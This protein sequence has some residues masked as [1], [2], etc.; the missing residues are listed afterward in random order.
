MLL[1]ASLFLVQCHAC[2]GRIPLQDNPDDILQEISNGTHFKSNEKENSAFTG[3]DLSMGKTS[4]LP[5]ASIVVPGLGRDVL[6]RRVDTFLHS[7]SR[8]TL[9]PREVVLMFSDIPDELCASQTASAR[10]LLPLSVT[11]I[12]NCSRSK[13]NQADARN[14]G[15]SLAGG[16]L[17]IFSDADDPMHFER[18]ETI[19]RIFQHN[20]NLKVFAHSFTRSRS[21][22]STSLMR[23]IDFAEPLSSHS[24]NHR[25]TSKN[26]SIMW[27]DS[28]QNEAA[29]RNFDCRK[30]CWFVNGMV[31]GA[32]T[33]RRGVMA[34]LPFPCNSVLRRSDG[35][36]FSED[37]LWLRALLKKFR[38]KDEA[39]YV[40]LPLIFYIPNGRRAAVEP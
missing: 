5:T 22:L 20:Q 37:T 21:L 1:L 29:R 8:Q 26:V 9:L 3:R 31:P 12:M 32:S 30:R 6:S 34:S 39:L 2:V 13:L 11:V 40:D 4:L 28:L 7:V 35:G 27:G 25:P 18:V 17:V 10:F 19:A 23:S 38:G 14:S 33:T 36:C 15:S 24:I 16:D